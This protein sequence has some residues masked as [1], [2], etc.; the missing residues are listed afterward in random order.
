MTRVH[1]TSRGLH[2]LRTQ[3]T[4][5][6]EFLENEMRVTDY[7]LLLGVRKGRFCVETQGD[8]RTTFRPYLPP[9]TPGSAPRPQSPSS[10]SG[11]ATPV[12]DHSGTASLKSSMSTA[13][14]ADWPTPPFAAAATAGGAARLPAV[15]SS[16]TMAVAT[17][18]EPAAAAPAGG[19]AAD[20][21]AV[22]LPLA[23]RAP[24]G[25]TIRRRM[26]GP[27]GATARATAGATAPAA[28][29]GGRRRR[30]AA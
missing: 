14:A 30:S 20:A 10:C 19:A 11:S 7:S 26:C 24:S 13:V 25:R 17:E 6:V 15:H 8:G 23:A 4:R 18:A 28:G 16:S 5:D 12:P 2:R 9:G 29:P 21:D 27:A 3:L 22:V 1:L